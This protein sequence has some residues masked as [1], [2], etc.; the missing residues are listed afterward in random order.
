MEASLLEKS[1]ALKHVELQLTTTTIQL[2]TK[3]A[4]M[5]GLLEDNREVRF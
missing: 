4:Y 1:S 5:E 3:S 2:E